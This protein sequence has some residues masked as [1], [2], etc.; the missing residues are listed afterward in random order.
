MLTD[1]T[2]RQASL[3]GYCSIWP[4]LGRTPTTPVARERKGEEMTSPEAGETTLPLAG[5]KLGAESCWSR[6]VRE[7][8]AR[9]SVTASR[10]ASRLG[11]RAELPDGVARVMGFLLAD[12]GCLISGRMYAVNGRGEM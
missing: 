10:A 2:L 11:G 1:S 8:L 12:G 3:E 6:A 5:E 7:G 9:R 4:Y